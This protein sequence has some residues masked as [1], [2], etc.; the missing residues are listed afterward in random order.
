MRKAILQG[1]MSLILSGCAFVI[2]PHTVQDTPSVRGTV[3]NREVPV[4]GV[5]VYLQEHS[6]EFCERTRL[7]AT[8]DENGEFLIP[9]QRKLEIVVV[10]GDRF[11]SLGL[12]VEIDG[13]LH[14]A[15]SGGRMGEPPSGMRIT[16]R[17]G[18]LKYPDFSGVK[19]CSAEGWPN[20]AL[21]PTAEQAL[22][23]DRG[24]VCRGGLT[25]R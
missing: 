13:D 2:S 15:W 23:I 24:T 12:C 1:V 18:K 3:L 5:T 25:R 9:G 8:S 16:C 4:R 11:T 21:K 17:L 14:H 19:A 22:R 7:K 6:R 10:M 20:Y